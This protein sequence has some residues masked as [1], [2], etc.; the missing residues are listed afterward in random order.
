MLGHPNLIV[1]DLYDNLID[2]AG[3]AHLT[4]L[5]TMK[6]LKLLQLYS[7]FRRHYIY[8]CVMRIPTGN[9][10]FYSVK[11]QIDKSDL[12]WRRHFSVRA[13]ER[14]YNQINTSRVLRAKFLCN[15]RS[16]CARMFALVKRGR[17]TVNRSVPGWHIWEIVFGVGEDSFPD[18]IQRNIIART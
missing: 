10:G 9:P 17:A 8:V 2:K 3:C 14:V 6:N 13:I 18:D 4:E 7:K 12:G 16:M 11:A 15:Y 1:L 5:I